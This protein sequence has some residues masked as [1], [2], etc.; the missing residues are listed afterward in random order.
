MAP[1]YELSPGRPIHEDEDE[2]KGDG[3]DANKERILSEEFVVDSDEG[4][5]E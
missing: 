3:E 4:V 5:V 2:D 1:N